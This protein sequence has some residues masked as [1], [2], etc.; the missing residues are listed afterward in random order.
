MVNLKIIISLILV[1]GAYLFWIIGD[2]FRIPRT[3]YLPKWGWIIVVLG[4]IPVGGIAYY[5]L[6][7]RE[8][9]W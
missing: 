3:R 8:G 1:A 9:G 7:R 4:V 6:E 5:L 2:I